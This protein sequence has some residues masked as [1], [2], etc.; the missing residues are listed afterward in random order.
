MDGVREAKRGRVAVK[1]FDFGQPTCRYQFNLA[2]EAGIFRYLMLAGS[3]SFA[4][5][6]PG[7]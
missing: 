6:S 3:S 7:P 2:V 4:F 5:A 1:K